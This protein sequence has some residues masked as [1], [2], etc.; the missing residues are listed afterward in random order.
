MTNK[1]NKTEI[2]RTPLSNT[3]NTEGLGFYL[4]ENSLLIALKGSGNLANKYDPIKSIFAYDLETHTFQDKP[5]MSFKV[6]MLDSIYPNMSG[7]IKELAP[8]GIAYNTINEEFYVISC[9][10]KLLM[11]LNKEKELI[12]IHFLHE[13]LYLQPEGICFDLDNKLYISNE[14]QHKTASYFKFQLNK[15]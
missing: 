3:H 7:R 5:F 10:G 9:R 2:I 8:L 4:D 13:D 15:K 1:I 11:R 14:G 12:D 6:E